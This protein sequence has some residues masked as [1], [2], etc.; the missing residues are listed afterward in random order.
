MSEEERRS[1]RGK[2]KQPTETSSRVEEFL[3]PFLFTL[4]VRVLFLSSVSSPFPLYLFHLLPS[5]IEDHC[6]EERKSENMK[7]RRK[8]NSVEI[9]RC[10]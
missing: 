9:E 1:E 8:R 10:A 3:T 2:E 6:V 4:S 5:S 7:R